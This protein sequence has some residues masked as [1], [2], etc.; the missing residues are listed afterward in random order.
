MHIS[1]EVVQVDSDDDDLCCICNDGTSEETNL[2]V[3]CDACD[4]AYHQKCHTPIL[5]DEDIV[6]DFE[7]HSCQANLTKGKEATHLD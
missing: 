1:N 4:K 6:G 7:C 3:F 2:I 5:S